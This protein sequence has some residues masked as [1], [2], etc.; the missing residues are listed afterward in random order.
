MKESN[1]HCRFVLLISQL[2]LAYQVGESVAVKRHHDDLAEVWYGEEVEGLDDVL[3][4]SSLLLA[5]IVPLLHHLQDLDLLTGRLEPFMFAEGHLHGDLHALERHGR[6][7]HPEASSGDQLGFLVSFGIYHC[8][9]QLEHGFF[10][11]RVVFVNLHIFLQNWIIE[12][13]VSQHLEVLVGLILLLL[14]GQDLLVFL[15]QHFIQFHSL[16]LGGP[17]LLI[18]IV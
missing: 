7:H 11:N 12:Q 5:F 2:A 4:P 16:Q 18:I 14:Q 10:I 17:E 13:L 1:D 8:T 15:D 3:E 9:G 6:E